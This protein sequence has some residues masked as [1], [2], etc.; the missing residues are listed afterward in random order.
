MKSKFF[1]KIAISLSIGLAFLMGS[2]AVLAAQP[3]IGNFKVPAGQQTLNYQSPIYQTK[4]VFTGIIAEWNSPATNSHIYLRS[5]ATAKK[6]WSKWMSIEA[7]ID[8]L[9]ELPKTLDAIVNIAPSQAYQYKVVL[10]NKD[11]ELNGLKFTFI[12]VK[13]PNG[14]T[15]QIAGSA[16]YVASSDVSGF[17]PLITR[18]QWGAVDDYNYFTRVNGGNLNVD[19]TATANPDADK[20]ENVSP[21]DP[22]IESI[23]TNENGHDLKWPYEYAKT[24]RFLVV[25]HTVSSAGSDPKQALRNIQ[26]YHAI[27]RG[28]GDIGYN[29]IVDPEGRIYEGR[30]GGEKVIGGHSIPVNQSSIGISV[31]GNYQVEA[32]SQE[33]LE[34]LSRILTAKAEL[35]NLNP[36]ATD[37]FNNKVY[38]VIG[39]HRDSDSTACPGEFL[40]RSLPAVKSLV[41]RSMSNFVPG[42][43]PALDLNPLRELT[44]LDPQETKTIDIAVKN[45]STET[46]KRDDVY[47][48]FFNM[49]EV[50][51]AIKFPPASPSYKVTSLVETHDIAPNE[52]A[53]FRLTVTGTNKGGFAYLYLTPV[54]NQKIKNNNL[55]FVPI[56]VK[57]GDLNFQ[58]NSATTQNLDLEPGETKML[59]VELKNTGNFAWNSTPDTTLK[60]GMDVPRDVNSMFIQENIGKGRIWQ[61]PQAVAP[62][63]SV[64]FNLTIKAPAIRTDRTEVLRPVIDGFGWGVGTPLTIHLKNT[65]TEVPFVAQ[66][67]NAG[68]SELGKVTRRN[69][70]SIKAPI[71]ASGVDSKTVRIN[72]SYFDKVATDVGLNSNYKLIVDNKLKRRVRAFDAVSVKEANGTVTVTVN[73]SSYQGRVVRIIPVDAEVGVF[74]LKGYE[75]RPGWNL[76]LNDNQFR[77]GA[78][79]RIDGG[80]LITINELPVAHYLRGIAEVS[81]G[82]DPEMIKTLMILARTY[83]VYYLDPARN[84]FKD[85]PY[86][87]DDSPDRSQKYLGYGFEQRSPNVSIYMADV[88][89]QVVVYNGQIVITPYFSRSDGRTR[90]GQEVWGWTNTPFLVSVPDTYCANASADTAAGHGVGLS[91]CGG[92][93]MAAAG[94]GYQE[95]IKYFYKGVTIEQR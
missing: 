5:Q 74:Q 62:G 39:G 63:A 65:I 83:S 6:E 81:N 41:A 66:S 75:H 13:A 89:S 10:D 46:W 58:F 7:D 19:T 71:P 22:D 33:V 2:Q 36:L 49:A 95:I 1:K 67:I 84:K 8:H 54:V 55:I 94:F 68:G 20:D 3:I 92:S 26:Y 48:G 64:K 91:G 53:T 29:Y 28:W 50:A 17:V 18:E 43:M 11:A 15:A 38:P 12:N 51:N 61:A 70:A 45:I 69:Y 34:A 37:T 72:L 14:P 88:I 27:K 79:F 9:A 82:S 77:G 73:N 93:G 30:K 76:A 86:D 4:G 47:L 60:L 24:I 31:M 35:Y 90:S 44:E 57:K 32:P 42:D 80:K 21:T 59:S 23:V 52:T 16:N 25:H 87:L 85:K 40:Y 78:E 56:Y